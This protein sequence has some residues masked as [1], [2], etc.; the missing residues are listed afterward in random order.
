MRVDF[1]DLSTWNDF[2]NIQP[3]TALAM[4][5]KACLAD[6]S[7]FRATLNAQQKL[8]PRCVVVV[9]DNIPT[10]DGVVFHGDGVFSSKDFPKT[11][12]DGRFSVKCCSPPF[13][14]KFVLKTVKVRCKKR[15]K[16][17]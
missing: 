11:K 15:G 9:G 16:G 14:D 2:F 6:A 5:V 7:K 3:E 12:G 10:S 4:H 17:K 13:S 8:Y 1:Y